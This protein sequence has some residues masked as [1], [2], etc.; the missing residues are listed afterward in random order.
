MEWF[1]SVGSSEEASGKKLQPQ[2]TEDVIDFWLHMQPAE[3][4]HSYCTP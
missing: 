3:S 1:L 4:A 2:V